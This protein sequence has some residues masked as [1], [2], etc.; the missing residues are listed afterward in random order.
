[1]TCSP[2]KAVRSIFVAALLSFGLL[3]ACSRTPKVVRDLPELPAE[4]ARDLAPART[5]PVLMTTPAAIATPVAPPPASPPPPLV[6]ARACTSFWGGYVTYPMTV[7]YPPNDQIADLVLT[8]DARAPSR[9]GDG[10]GVLPARYFKLTRHPRVAIVKPWFCSVRGGPWFAKVE[11]NQ[12]CDANPNIRVFKAEILG[13]P[14][15]VV[16]NWIGALT[17]VPPPLQLVGISPDAPDSCKCCSG[18]TCPDG[19][20]KPNFNLCGTMPPAVK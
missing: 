5:A 6:I 11:G 8:Q 17:D 2:D 10:R 20:C 13:A 7:C 16:V 1:M 14:E 18:I 19:S 3:M 15:P 9:R 12:K 4:L